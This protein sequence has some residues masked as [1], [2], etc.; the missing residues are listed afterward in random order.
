MTS[1]EEGAD[2]CCKVGAVAEAYELGNLDATLRERWTAAEDRSGVRELAD[3]VNTRLVRSTLHARHEGS[4]S[5]EAENY[6]RLLTDD[7]VSRGM[8]AEARGRLRDRG[9]DVGALEDRFVSHQTVYRHLTDCLGLDRESAPNDPETA[10]RDAVGT[11]RALQRR[12]EVVATST[13]ERLERAD[14]VDVGELDVLVDV[15]VSCR[16]CGERFPLSESLAGRS[17]D[18]GR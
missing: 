13:L 6:Y 11:I 15:V 7:D 17:C 3:H 16:V 5:G 18:C 8:R 2:P 9:V 10:V 12:T 1:P 14:H 4:L